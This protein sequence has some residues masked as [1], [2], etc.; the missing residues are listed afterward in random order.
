MPPII[1][2]IIPEK[3]GAPEARAIPRHKGNAT[4]KTTREDLRSALR[5]LFNGGSGNIK[6]GNVRE[7][8]EQFS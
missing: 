3:A 6:Y 7:L 2:A 1:P 5:F 8:V 4:R